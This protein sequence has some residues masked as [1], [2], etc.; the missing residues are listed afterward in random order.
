MVKKKNFIYFFLLIFLFSCEPDPPYTETDDPLPR[1][2]SEIRPL[3]LLFENVSRVYIKEPF[4][5]QTIP[6]E[7]GEI[8]FSFFSVPKG[9]IIIF[10]KEPA[11]ESLRD[12]SLRENC[13]A[14][15]SSL[16]GHAWNGGSATFS[17]SE[18]TNQFYKCGGNNLLSQ[19]EK[20][21]F[22]EAFSKG[23][24]FF[25]VVGYDDNFLIN[26]VSEIRMFIIE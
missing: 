24:Y 15:F 22:S 8:S 13:V 9:E 11:I 25:F 10:N 7:Q 17:D 4:L 2:D 20:I 19:T 26:K 23:T 14:G 3:P 16:A 1:Y 21:K 5:F 18:G 12:G 6:L